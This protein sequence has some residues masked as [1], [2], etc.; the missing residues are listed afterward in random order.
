MLRTILVPLDGSRLAE[1]ALK[2]ATAIAVPTGAGLILMRVVVETEARQ[3]AERYLNDTA[4][5]L[6]QRGF[7]C[8]T[9]TPARSAADWMVAEAESREV[10]LVAM[11]THGRTGPG[12][13]LFGSVAESVVASSLV[14][15]LVE[16]AW[17]PIRRDPLLTER[18]TLL[19]P[20]DGSALAELALQPA[21]DLADNLGGELILLRVDARATDVLRDEF[22][23]TIESVDQQEDRA[24]ELAGDYLNRAASA[25]RT[26]WPS[27]PV[28]TETGLGA[29][30]AGIVDAATRANAAIVF[31]ATHGHTGLRRAVTGSVAGE[32]LE[33]GTTPLILIR[34]AQARTPA[35]AAPIAAGAGYA[36]AYF[37]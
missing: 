23:R 21:C 18:P 11:S 8:D 20:L 14:P 33:Q 17:Q 29:P 34:P 31:M 32:V 37:G 25:V 6:R 5:G 22:G 24:R 15:V 16:R 10:D 12:R 28:H 26:Q 7:D 35:S 2:Y 9:A 13:W 4:R 30:A 1:R 3:A 36:S 19:V 27:L